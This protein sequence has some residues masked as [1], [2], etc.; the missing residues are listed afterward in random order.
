M[1]SRGQRTRE[2]LLAVAEQQ[3]VAEHGTLDV[4]RVAAAAAISVGGL[5]HHFP[6]KEA[7]LAAVV[8]AF[9]DR[10]DA[11]VLFADLG[12]VGD[13][14][15]RERERVR[16]AVQFYYEQPL[17]KV[18][19]ARAGV[20]GAIARVDAVRLQGAARASALNLGEAQRAGQ[21]PPELDCAHAGAMLM[22][23]VALVLARA[24][25]QSPRPSADDLAEA[26][27]VMVAGVVGLPGP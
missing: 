3:L 13:W 7:L 11:E 1:S 15:T 8:E 9:H 5:Y 20:D 19:L 14:A 4:D 2:R 17:A 16:R 21:L 10:Y 27:W 22:G 24:L 12:D 18:L 23:G 26:I 6:S 25:E